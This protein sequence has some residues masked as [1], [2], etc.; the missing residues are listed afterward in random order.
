MMVNWFL[1]TQVSLP[2]QTDTILPSYQLLTTE[3]LSILRM[4]VTKGAS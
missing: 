1:S 3:I 2:V 4:S